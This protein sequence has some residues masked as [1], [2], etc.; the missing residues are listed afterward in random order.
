[1][2][3]KAEGVA[4]N[5][6]DRPRTVVICDSRE[7]RS[8][9]AVR[10][11]AVP[12]ITVEQAELACGD[13]WI[14][15]LLV[16]ERKTATDFVLSVMD[17]RLF[18]QAARMA[19]VTGVRVLLLE[20]DP[21]TDTRSQMSSES[22]VGALSALPV[23]FGISV[24]R[25]GSADDSA[26]LIATMARHLV[27]GLGYDIPFRSAKPKSAGLIAQFLTEGLPGVGPST[28]RKLLAHFGSPRALFA[29][30]ESE[31]R[32]VKGVGPKLAA[33][34]LGALDTAYAG[35]DETRPTRR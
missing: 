22:I 32:A 10:L 25:S 9:I 16:V 7:A 18:E 34:I 11:A 19:T 29:A 27:V 31:L 5:P 28:A 12:G 26:L 14:E 20:G 8:G 23:F 15:D 6:S 24:L 3:L 33:S 13:Y 35:P 2:A 30:G 1:M 17:G 21:L 4:E